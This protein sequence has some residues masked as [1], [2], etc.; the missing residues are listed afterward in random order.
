MIFPFQVYV[1]R[2]SGR[3]VMYQYE[4]FVPKDSQLDSVA[5]VSQYEWI[6]GNWSKCSKQCARG[7]EGV[8]ESIK[9]F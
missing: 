8:G 5:V 9:G 4:Y 7:K 1:A 6:V 3:P 2:Y